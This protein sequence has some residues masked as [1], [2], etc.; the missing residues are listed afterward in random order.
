MVAL[1]HPGLV[2]RRG[3]S[4]RR[5]VPFQ[6]QHPLTAGTAALGRVQAVQARAQDDLIV[7]HG[8]SFLACR[9]DHKKRLLRAGVQGLY[10][11]VSAPHRQRSRSLLPLRPL[12][13][14]G[15]FS[16]LG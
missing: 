14:V 5:S 12:I 16:P 3:P 2:D 15:V 7:G 13:L 6:H 10:F 8:D 9:A 11:P 4:E 1:V